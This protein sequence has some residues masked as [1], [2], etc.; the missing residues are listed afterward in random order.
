V[1]FAFDGSVLSVR[2]AEKSMV[3]AAEGTP[4]TTS[5]TIP[6]DKL[7]ELP[8]R[9]MDKRVI[10][11]VWQTRLQIARRWYEGAASVGEDPIE[12]PNP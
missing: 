5:Y 1:T 3:M 10:V 8:K 12:E 7:R 11:S 9:L 6:A 2:C 4:W